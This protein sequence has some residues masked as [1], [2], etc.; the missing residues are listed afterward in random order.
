MP[1][2]FK[3]LRFFNLLEVNDFPILSI[4]KV[5]AWIMIIAVVVI[6]FTMPENIAAVIAASGGNAIAM[7]NYAHKRHLAHKKTPSKK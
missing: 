3:I 1:L 7:L 2:F 6:L 5:F 4:S